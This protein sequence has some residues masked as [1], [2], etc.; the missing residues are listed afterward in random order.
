MSL[1]CSCGDYDY[2]WWYIVGDDTE[3]AGVDCKCGDCKAPIA[4]G[5]YVQRMEQ[6]EMDE[7]G[8]EVEKGTF[9][10]CEKCADIYHSLAELGFCITIGRGEMANAIQEYREMRGMT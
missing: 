8:E 1:S 5:D 2:E 4:A 3:P 7:D 6:F 9:L 10:M